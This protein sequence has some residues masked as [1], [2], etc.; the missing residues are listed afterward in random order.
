MNV[1]RS[2]CLVLGSSVVLAVMLP[3]LLH[4]QAPNSQPAGEAVE[5]LETE[6][7]IAVPAADSG[8]RK[9]GSMVINVQKD[10]SL[11]FREKTLALDELSAQLAD[12]AKAN[13][14]QAIIIRG[15]EDTPYDQIVKVL[16]ATHKAGLFHVSF[17]SVKN[18]GEE[19]DKQPAAPEPPAPKAQ[20]VEEK[21]PEQ[22]KPE[23]IEHKDGTRTEVVGDTAKGQAVE[24]TYRN[25]EV[26]CKRMYYNDR[27]GRARQG[28]ICDGKGAP[29]GSILFRYDKES[30]EPTEEQQYNKDGKL[31]RRLFYP[32]ALKDP[33]YAGRC[34]AFTYP[35][36]IGGKPVEEPGD[37]TPTLPAAEVLLEQAAALFTLGQYAP[38]LESVEKALRMNPASEKAKA[39][40]EQVKAKLT[41]PAEAPG[42]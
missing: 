32:G 24:T 5:R 36:G 25:G 1:V 29:T 12:V 3:G 41:S 34:V 19:K 28:V 42:R 16:N 20:S 31:I 9:T 17:A 15:A 14:K 7:K 10:G 33:K 26:I 22:A 27:K 40:L 4:S 8:D 21:S 6:L 18:A 37:A 13:N 30:D 23:S 2:R 38:A 11:V 35:D 39:L